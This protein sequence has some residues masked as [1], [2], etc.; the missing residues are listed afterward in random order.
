MTDTDPSSVHCKYVMKQNWRRIFNYFNVRN[1]H[2]SVMAD[3]L[4]ID[5]PLSELKILVFVKPSHDSALPSWKVPGQILSH[6]DFVPCKQFDFCIAQSYLS[7]LQSA[8][9]P[10]VF[11]FRTDYEFHANAIMLKTTDNKSANL[12]HLLVYHVPEIQLDMYRRRTE[13]SLRY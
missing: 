3:L 2:L 4:S 10:V 11:T 1:T 8:Q 5:G 6:Q 9:K 7:R 13:R 12:E